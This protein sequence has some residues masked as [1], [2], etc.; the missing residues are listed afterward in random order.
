ML[1]IIYLSFTKHNI[2]VRG[3]VLVDVRLVDDKQ[4]VPGLADGHA[5]DSS[6]LPKSILVFPI[7]A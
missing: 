7:F 1:K 2:G 5:A 4:D 6:N 3:R